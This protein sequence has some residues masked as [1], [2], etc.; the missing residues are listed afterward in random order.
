MSI[1]EYKQKVQ[2]ARRIVAIGRDGFIMEPQPWVTVLNFSGGRQSTVI[3]WKLIRGELKISENCGGRLLVLTAD[4]GMEGARTYK[5]VEAMQRRARDA[6]L[7]AVTVEGP[8]LAQDLIEIGSK[9]RIDNPPFFTSRGEG[10]A[11]GRLRQKCTA[12]YKIAPMDRYIRKFWKSEFGGGVP[13]PNTVEKWIGFS[14]DERSRISTSNQSYVYFRYPLI[15]EGLTKEGCLQYLRDIGEEIPP[16]SVCRACPANRAE[17][18]KEMQENDPEGF[19]LAELIDS[20]IRDLTSVGVKETCFVHS[21]RLPLRE[22]VDLD[23]VD[24]GECG[25]GYCFT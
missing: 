20:R 18:F 9:N 2:K 7:H 12:F 16:P 22:V 3:L 8:D 23:D 25:S 19:E 15:E 21:S 24:E 17:T 6:G 4:P 14:D 10:K 5:H 13:K 11:G 1:E